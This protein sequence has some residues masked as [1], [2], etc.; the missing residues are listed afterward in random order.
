M[1]GIARFLI[2]AVALVLLSLIID[3]Q[4]LFRSR[5]TGTPQMFLLVINLVVLGWVLWRE[6]F[7]HLKPFDPVRVALEVEAT[8][9]ELSSVLVS[10][11]QFQ[12]EMPV[13]PSPRRHCW[14]LCGIKPSP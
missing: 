13:P 2:W 5:V 11:I 10:Y 7:R 12:G 8:H 3:W 6:W 4:I 9:P 14:T 1:R